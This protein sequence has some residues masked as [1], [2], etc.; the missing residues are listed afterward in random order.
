MNPEVLYG[1]ARRDVA[2]VEVRYASGLTRTVPVTGEAW[3]AVATNPQQIAQVLVAR[4]ADGDV[5]A[6][7]DVSNG[8]DSRG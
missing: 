7:I 3:I 4:N 5:V 8:G 1:F 2:S 6:T